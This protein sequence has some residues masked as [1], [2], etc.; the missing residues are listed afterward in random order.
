MRG[1]ER[2]SPHNHRIHRVVAELAREQP[3][4]SPYVVD[5]LVSQLQDPYS[6][7]M[8]PRQLTQFNTSTAG[9]YGGIGMRIEE[10]PGKGV[11]IVT[12]VPNTPAEKAGIREGDSLLIYVSR[13]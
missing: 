13:K 10:Q 5:R 12:V 6:E 2:P 1:S 3:T 4:P 7:L 11:T 8:S 9:R